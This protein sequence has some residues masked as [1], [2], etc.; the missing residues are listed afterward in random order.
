[1]SETDEEYKQYAGLEYIEKLTENLAELKISSSQIF[2]DFFSKA[3][4]HLLGSIEDIADSKTKRLELELRNIRNTK[5]VSTRNLFKGSPVNWSN[6]WQF[7]SIEENHEKRKMCM[8]TLSE[9]LI[10]LSQ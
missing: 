7:N 4:E 1:V 5:I 9:R 6:W 8:T 10:T 3:R 2:I